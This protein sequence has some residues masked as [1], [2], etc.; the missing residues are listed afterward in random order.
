MAASSTKAPPQ[1]I[2]AIFR[3]SFHPTQ[4]SVLDW[5]LKASD[6]L[7]LDGV[8]FSSLPSGL[9][10]VEQDVVYF[11]KD[12]LR[13]V[14]VFTRRE[15]PEQGQRG[16][17]LRSLGVLLARSVRPRPWRHVPALKALV[18]ELQ[19]ETDSS[20]DIWAPARRFFE[21]RKAPHLE[22][23]DVD[24]W[25]RWSEELDFDVDDGGAEDSGDAFEYNMHA[26]PTL[27]LP[28][29]LRVLGPSS[30]T[31]YKHVLGRR[32]ILIYTQ[33]PVEAACLFC[34]VAADMC[35]EDQT[36]TA[37]DSSPEGLAPQLLKGKHK[38]GINVLGIVTLH[39][40]DMLERESRTGRGWIACTTDALFLEKPQHYD[41]VI[42]LTTYA[43]E[44]LATARPG[45]QLAI[46]ESYARR[47]TYRLSSVRFTWSDV[48]LW[49]ELERILQLDEDT[50][51]AARARAPPAIWTWTDAWGVYEDVCLVCAR[52]CSCLWRNN[53][54]S[55]NNS[56]ELRNQWSR[57]GS[58]R[59]RARREQRAKVRARGEG[60]EGR[61][62][63]YRRRGARTG[64]YDSSDTIGEADG[65]E[66]VDEV[67]QEEEEAEED[68]AVLVHSRQTRTTL[69]LLQ[70][71][72]AQT[73]FLLSRL[74]TVLPP[75][76]QMTPRDL[77][78]L[79]LGP[80]SALDARFVEWLAEEYVDAGEGEA[81]VLV[82]RGWRDLLGGLVGAAVGASGTAS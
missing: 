17:R 61:P 8:E 77:V 38:E 64:K 1:D 10:L 30:L 22:L 37:P 75:D 78:V 45:L 11:T 40:I 60:I 65:G 68:G 20:E 32:R 54:S 67:E 44:R 39:D 47:P 71:F 9:H 79:E 29:L 73:R 27:H 46:K 18:R 48:K 14:C 25:H 42:D 2:V 70:T 69:A 23:G 26:S 50:N 15:T 13:G 6:D 43:S 19:S 34:Q 82:R 58:P 76:G 21:Q 16:F 53:G 63:S 56:S 5:S 74:A 51:G 31:L 24:T 57:S 59:T 36:T 49:T 12:G 28:H 52:L 66:V 80:L 7:N 62:A 72:H 4:G 3:T 33:P 41:L 81:S 35:F 55:N